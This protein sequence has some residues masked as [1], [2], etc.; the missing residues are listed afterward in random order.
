MA[1]A[2]SVLHRE[3]ADQGSKGMA[4][5]GVAPVIEEES[6]L[7]IGANEERTLIKDVVLK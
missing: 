3:A 6:S 7:V 1:P 2:T 5:V 4:C